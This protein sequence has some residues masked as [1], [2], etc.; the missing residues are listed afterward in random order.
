MKAL[1]WLDY[2]I[3][4]RIERLSHSVQRLTGF[5]CFHQ[6]D[7]MRI[8]AAVCYLLE[9]LGDARNTALGWAR[10]PLVAVFFVLTVAMVWLAIWGGPLDQIYR[11]EPFL[12]IAKAD[13]NRA[14]VRVWMFAMGSVALLYGL[15][16][17]SI[18]A[19]IPLAF[20]LALDSCNPLPPGSGKIRE[21]IRGLFRRPLVLAPT[22]A[23]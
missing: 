14:V 22:R 1:L 16:N 12:N 4:T 10:W 2:Q 18:T 8:A 20:A 6:R 9:M 23:S 21:W 17:W 5:D 11:E 19:I 13:P 3:L 15:T 7:A